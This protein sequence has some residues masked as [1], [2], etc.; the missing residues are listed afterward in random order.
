LESI[1]VS[2]V[3]PMRKKHFIEALRQVRSSVG[4][5]DLKGYVEW[6]KTFGSFETSEGLT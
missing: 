6:N 4:P 3:P 2:S 5:D 1:D